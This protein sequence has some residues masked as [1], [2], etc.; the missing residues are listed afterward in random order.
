MSHFCLAP[1]LIPVSTSGP[2]SILQGSNDGGDTLGNPTTA[3]GLEDIPPTPAPT[4]L[5]PAFQGSNG[6]DDTVGNPTGAPDLVIPPTPGPTALPTPRPTPI[7][8]DSPTIAPTDAPVFPG[9]VTKETA[10]EQGAAKLAE[11]FGAIAGNGDSENAV[12]INDL[13][14]E[15]TLDRSSESNTALDSVLNFDPANPPFATFQAP[16]TILNDNGSST[17]QTLDGNSITTNTDGSIEIIPF[18]SVNPFFNPFNR[19]RVRYLRN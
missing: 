15:V 5:A 3:P 18:A 14:A 9:E 13:F 11:L 7:P 2:P 1:L 8:P 17:E 4:V 16:T 12:G 19:R 10:D 6:S